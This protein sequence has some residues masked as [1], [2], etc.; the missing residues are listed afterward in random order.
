M[1]VIMHSTTNIWVILTEGTGCWTVI[2]YN[3]RRANGLFFFFLDMTVPYSF[4][5]L[6]A[7]VLEAE[8]TPGS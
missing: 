7:F 3:T 1:Q 5:F 2:G 4:L 8:W 6:A